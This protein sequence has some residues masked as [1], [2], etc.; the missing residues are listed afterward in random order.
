MRMPS[1]WRSR[2]F[3]V[4]LVAQVTAVVTLLWPQ[5]ESA[6][7]EVGA[8]V[9]ALLVMGMSAVG[10]V[11]TEGSIDRERTAAATRNGAAE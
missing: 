9:S 1:R 4:T 2:K 3:L 8:A 7:A 11:L 10:Y 6:I 5:H